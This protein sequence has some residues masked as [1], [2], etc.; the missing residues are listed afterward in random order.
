MLAALCACDSGEGDPTRD[1][2][3]SSGDGAPMAMCD[4]TLDGFCPCHARDNGGT[5]Y[6]FCPDVVTWQEARDNCRRF[7]F[8]LVRI[9]DEAEQQYVWGAAEALTGD[10][11]IGLHDTGTEGEYEWSDGTP[12]GS[13]AHWASMAPND[14][15]GEVAE[16]CVEIL[17]PEEGGWNDR[18]CATDYLD[19]IC[20]AR[21]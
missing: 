14:G 17:Q 6:L 12:L 16:D 1:G 4:G 15:D 19:Y 7:G 21:L 8:E 11:W 3:M 5:R 2:G 13:Y 18:D 10:F 9:D 20:E